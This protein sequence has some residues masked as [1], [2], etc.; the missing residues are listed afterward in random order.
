[1]Y[2]LDVFTPPLSPLPSLS[3]TR[4][5]LREGR[6]HF[7]VVAVAFLLTPKQGR[8]KDRCLCSR[9]PVSV[10]TLLVKD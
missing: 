6:S 3:I 9:V 8:E 10:V 7:V 4:Q 5:R 2:K 1:M